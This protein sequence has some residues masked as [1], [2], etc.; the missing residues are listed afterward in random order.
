MQFGG[1]VMVGFGGWYESS[2]LLTSVSRVIDG[3]V[4]L[5]EDV[6]RVKGHH[7]YPLLIVEALKVH[8]QMH[9]LVLL[10]FTI[11]LI[12]GKLG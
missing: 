4:C 8:L 1:Y 9:K 10:L 6:S 12:R 3:F 11:Q 5:D 2:S 7:E